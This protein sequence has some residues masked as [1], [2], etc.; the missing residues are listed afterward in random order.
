MKSKLVKGGLIVAVAFLSLAAGAEPK[1]NPPRKVIVGTVCSRF[2]GSPEVRA[3]QG[4]RQLDEMASRAKAEHGG[5]RLDLAV[6]PEGCLKREAK[7]A[8]EKTVPL[9]FVF[10][11]F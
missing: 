10:L 3:E 9:D 11:M 8:A 1:D 2:K 7:T 4:V 5:R 6:F